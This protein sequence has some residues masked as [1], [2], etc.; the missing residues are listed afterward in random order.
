MHLA[1]PLPCHCEERSDV[2]ISRCSVSYTKTGLSTEN[3]IRR[4]V[5]SLLVPPDLQHC[6]RRLPRRGKIPL[7]AMTS[8]FGSAYVLSYNL[9]RSGVTERV[10]AVTIRI[11]P[12]T[13]CPRPLAAK[14]QFIA[15][16]R[17]GWAQWCN[18]PCRPNRPE[19][20]AATGRQTTVYL[21]T[22]STRCRRGH[23]P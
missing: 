10:R 22:D 4:C 16:Y 1:A 13:H 8:F 18:D 12:S 19:L 17:I 3:V 9:K 21:T 5:Q 14:L 6:T 23:R 11:A 20:S 7:L 2:A 15:L